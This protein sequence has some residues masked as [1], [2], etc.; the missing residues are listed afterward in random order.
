[1]PP[2]SLALAAG[3]GELTCS[4]A[5]L[6]CGRELPGTNAL[7]ARIRDRR[8]EVIRPVAATTRLIELLAGAIKAR[9]GW[10]LEPT[11]AAAASALATVSA[12]TTD[13]TERRS[14]EVIKVPLE[15]C[16]FAAERQS[17]PAAWGRES[18][19]LK[20]RRQA[21]C[22]QVRRLVRPTY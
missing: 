13:K 19:L 4:V 17:S 14:R 2:R 15:P 11:G 7:A 22:G 8:L 18:S 21:P 5:F 6:A 10:P 12:G 3:A 20:A 16:E 9:L 1:M